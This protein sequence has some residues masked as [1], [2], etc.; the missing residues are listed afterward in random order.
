VKYDYIIVGGGST[1]CVLAA[2][3]SEDPAKS[4]LLL[5]AGP[6]YPDLDHLPDELKFGYDPVASYEGAAHNWSFKGTA[7]SHTARQ[8]PVPRGKVMGG[9]SAINVQAFIRGVPED[10][11][12][13]AAL[14]NDQ[15]SFVNVLADF[16]KSETDQDIR[17]DFHGTDG[18]I[19]VRR[20]R[21]ESWNR[22][23][24]A[25]FQAC[26]AAGFP[27]AWDQNNPDA[28]GVGP[29]PMNNPDG[30]RMSTA[31][32]YINPIRHRLNLSVRSNMLARRILFDRKKATGVAVD[33]GGDTFE[34]E[35]EEIIL[36]AG[37]IG[38]PH[39]L[40]LSGVG[41]ARQLNAHGVSLILDLPGVGQN[42]RDHPLVFT[43][44]RF[45][46]GY[47]IDPNAPRAQICLRYTAEGSLT[48]DDLM[49]LPSSS[50]PF[51]P[52]EEAYVVRIGCGL[53]L[54]VGSG[55][56]TLDSKDPDVQ[57]QINYHYL[58]D[59]WDLQRM[60]EGVRLAVRLSEHKAYKDI[61]AE[62][63]S[64]ADSDLTSDDALD[65]WL[66]DNVSSFQHISGTC[67]MGPTSDPLAVVD[68]YCNVRGM[69]GLRVV[70]ASIFPDIVRANTN[71]TAVM[72]GERV[73]GFIREGR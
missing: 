27:E 6:D 40:M 26:V 31:L 10:Y 22:D 68:Q 70:D 12:A 62:R 13:W 19:P 11:D 18:P 61:V 58:E 53:E 14:G 1:G 67:K 4:V 69:E 7:S 45:P 32:T 44:Y 17:D 50:S 56:L 23:Q 2:R 29:L 9:S 48:R 8:I 15:W 72:I 3:L 37:A 33:S 41:P 51:L 38:S 24:E 73:A 66:I 52:G 65:A 59:S 57:P 16:R 55:E 39:L 54:P 20:H 63:I 42:L 60:R 64:P 21:R 47:S 35:G 43:H 49:I 30:I 34:V 28:T 5:E 25:F 46:D 36:S 71:A